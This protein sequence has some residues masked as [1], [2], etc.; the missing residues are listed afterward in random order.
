LRCVCTT[1]IVNPH[2]R[3]YYDHELVLISSRSPDHCNL[4]RSFLMFS[5]LFNL[6]N[7][8]SPSSTT[9]FL[10]LRP[11]AFKTSFINLSSIS[12]LVRIFRLAMYNHGMCTNYQLYTHNKSSKRDAV[13]GAPS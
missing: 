2:T 7:V 13:T 8:L 11:V 5:C 12:I 1:E 3:V 10:V 6:I 9:S 4:P